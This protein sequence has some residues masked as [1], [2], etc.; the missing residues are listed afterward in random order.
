MLLLVLGPSVREAVHVGD[1]RADGGGRGDWGVR[2]RRTAGGSDA[3]F[4]R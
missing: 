4:R 2:R 3:R 1:D